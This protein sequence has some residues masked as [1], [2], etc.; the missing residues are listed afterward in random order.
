MKKL[1]LSA[2]L[3][4]AFFVLRGQPLPCGPMPEMT[5]FCDDACIICDIDGFTGVNTDNVVGQMPQGF[6]TTTAHHMK[7][8]GFIAGSTSLT[9][10]FDVFNCQKN[11]GLEVGIYKSLDCNTFQSVAPCNTDIP[12]NTSWTFTTNV[13]L[14]IG[15][16][17]YLVTDGSN[18][19]VCNWK[20]NVLAGTTEVLPL[21]PTSGEITGDFSV[22]PNRTEIYE[23][24][25]PVGAAI[26]DWTLD[27]VNIKS[28]ADTTVTIDWIAPGE[29]QLCAAASNVC[30]EAAPVCQTIVVAPVPDTTIN[31]AICSGDCVDVAD[32]TICGAGSWVFHFQGQE[33]CDS[34]VR[35]NAT[36]LPTKTTTLDLLICAGDSVWVAGKPYFTEDT[37]Q[38]T[39]TSVNGCDSSLI[40]HLKLIQ[41]E[42][43]GK[44]ATDSVDCWGRQTGALRFWTTLS[45]PPLTY[46]WERIDPGTP[47]GSGQILANNA[48]VIVPNL[49]AGTYFITVMD[50]FGNDAVLIGYVGQPEKLKTQLAAPLFNGFAV[51]CWGEATGSVSA[52]TTGGILP[53][54]FSFSNGQN[55][56]SPR[57]ENLP[58]GWWQVTV[59]DGNGCTTS[60][61]IE[62][63]QPEKIIFEGVFAD[64]TC[65][66]QNTGAVAET[67]SA[68]GVLPFEYSL[69]GGLFGQKK[70]F[71]SLPPG[72]T[73]LV[74]RDA[75]GCEARID[76]N[77]TAPIIPDISI[78][79]PL[80][81]FLGDSVQLEMLSATALETI[82]WAP[83]PVLSCL[84]CQNPFARPVRDALFS[85]AVVAPG[86]GCV[87]STSVAVRVLERRRVF[88]PNVFSPDDDGLNDI[89][90]VFGGSEVRK[91]KSLQI[92]SRWG[93]LLFEQKDFQPGDE[94]MGWDGRFRGKKM[95]PTVVTWSAEVEFIDDETRFFEGD[96][97]L[98]H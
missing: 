97:T 38:D 53:Y 14:V 48:P 69:D 50:G 2:C 22:C 26:F 21:P 6:C 90:T 40:I 7:W 92:F 18:D 77:L 44:T 23:L 16:H 45:T 68:G 41:C 86:L 32:T 88:V 9:I 19:D 60:A 31:L 62:L 10:K 79:G 36:I 66:G 80:E 20:I 39:L 71:D 12:P 35:V 49:P 51:G 96:L 94:K 5:S 1:T 98:A 55:G 28:G 75:N 73:E 59:T 58:V 13:P 43:K 17:Y 25:P 85:V 11:E 82:S 3:F 64:P 34:I 93:E 74:L 83:N 30:D 29:H 76:S 24:H 46:S 4:L 78:T 56:P 91:I 70:A 89:F 84:D 52:A 72:P 54:D 61:Q 37:F 8:I 15:Q 63:K 57:I 95:A 81:I 42:I 27:G 33:N 65:A 67:L 87:D 47:V